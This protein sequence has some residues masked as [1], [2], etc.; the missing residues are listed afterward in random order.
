MYYTLDCWFTEKFHTKKKALSSYHSIFDRDLIKEF[1]VSV[2]YIKEQ[3]NSTDKT[4]LNKSAGE[5][6]VGGGV[7]L[8]DW[9]MDGN[10]SLDNISFD[11]QRVDDEFDD[12]K[13]SEINIVV[14]F[15]ILPQ[16]IGIVLDDQITSE[17]VLQDTQRLI[18]AKRFDKDFFNIFKTNIEG[19]KVSPMYDQSTEKF[20]END[21]KITISQRIESLVPTVIKMREGDHR[22]HNIQINR[23]K[24]S[25]IKSKLYSLIKF[26]N[27]QKLN[28]LRYIRPM[29]ADVIIEVIKC[30]SKI[31]CKKLEIDL[32]LK[33]YTAPPD[34]LLT[35]VKDE[36]KSSDVLKFGYQEINTGEE[37]FFAISTK[38]SKNF[39]F[40]K[41]S[42]QSEIQQ[43]FNR[44]GKH[45]SDK[46]KINFAASRKLDYDQK[47]DQ[48]NSFNFGKAKS[49]K[50]MMHNIYTP[51]G[52]FDIIVWLL[53]RIKMDKTGKITFIVT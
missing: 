5:I 21:C 31:E 23:Q 30:M 24:R 17:D 41:D 14:K 13:A 34:L 10:D 52:T 38:Y 28:L 18:N 8:G 11:A 33:E 37:I 39:D 15:E 44:L 7:I 32:N 3:L 6:E 35:M 43:P 4:A 26:F 27:E 40:E 50:E 46:F 49:S 47:S 22:N 20:N 45:M 12:S 19:A 1:I 36:I 2:D 29:N 53:I 9:N 51:Y 25:I 16:D 48:M 42:I